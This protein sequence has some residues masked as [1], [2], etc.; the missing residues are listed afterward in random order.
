MRSQLYLNGTFNPAK[1]ICNFIAGYMSGHFK[2]LKV[3]WY[4]ICMLQWKNHQD[5]EESVVGG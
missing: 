3:Y 2:D 5:H 4:T 1:S